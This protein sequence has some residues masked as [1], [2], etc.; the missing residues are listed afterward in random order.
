MRVADHLRSL[1]AY[2]QWANDRVLASAKQLT[3]TELDRELG[4]SWG[5]VRANLYHLVGAQM[6]WLNQFVGERRRELS[7]P[8]SRADLWASFDLSHD[9]LRSFADELSDEV[10]EQTFVLRDVDTWEPEQPLPLV[11]FI[12]HVVN[13]GTQHRAEI[14]TLLAQLGR[15]PGDV[16]YFFFVTGGSVR[17]PSSQ[18]R[19]CNPPN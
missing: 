7:W 2:N 19:T 4:G 17:F 5:C 3:E 16:D 11:P 15:S 9:D 10:L 12:V 18:G 14:G 6:S 1:I 8:I 13:H